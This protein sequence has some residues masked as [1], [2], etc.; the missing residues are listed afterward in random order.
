MPAGLAATLN[1]PANSTTTESISF[2]NSLLAQGESHV[3]HLCMRSVAGMRCFGFRPAATESW[4]GFALSTTARDIRLG[5]HAAATTTPDEPSEQDHPRTEPERSSGCAQSVRCIVDGRYLV[6]VSRRNLPTATV[7]APDQLPRR[8]RQFK[9][10]GRSTEH[11]PSVRHVA[12][13]RYFED[14]CPS[15]G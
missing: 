11:A 8:D 12:A 15:P 10:P 14:V 7:K 13:R 5:Q 6:G 3:P 9:E 2:L 4:S 1:S